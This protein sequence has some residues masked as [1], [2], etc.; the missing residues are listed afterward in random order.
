[1]SSVNV[2]YNTIFLTIFI[3][4]HKY[5]YIK[6][7]VIP[8]TIAID[9]RVKKNKYNLCSSRSRNQG[10]FLPSTNPAE[11]KSELWTKARTEEDLGQSP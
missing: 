3:D 9:S 1:L 6:D 2:E 5:V 8:M 10:S 7:R 11:R 4:G